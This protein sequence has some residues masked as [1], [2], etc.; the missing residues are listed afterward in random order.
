[1]AGPAPT[2]EKVAKGAFWITMTSCVLYIGAVFLFV[3]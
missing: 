1:M 2:S 3:L